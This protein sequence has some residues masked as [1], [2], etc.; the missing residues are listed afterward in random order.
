MP[1]RVVYPVI[2]SCYPVV[3]WGIFS[4]PNSS[5]NWQE[6]RFNSA[7]VSPLHLV[8]FA[9]VPYLFGAVWRFWMDMYKSYPNTFLR[10]WGGCLASLQRLW[11]PLGP[12]NTTAVIMSILTKKLF[13]SESIFRQ[14]RINFTT[15]AEQI[16][17]LCSGFRKFSCQKKQ[18]VKRYNAL[19]SSFR[20]GSWPL[21]HC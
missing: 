2:W 1:L 13:V 11:G 14:C 12:H 15:T 20:T 5:N 17:S 6:F 8:H 3:L 16:L 4:S 18:T 7:Q 9:K 19:I 10:R 21:S